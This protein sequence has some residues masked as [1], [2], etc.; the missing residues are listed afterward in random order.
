MK[1]IFLATALLS[2]A[3]AAF[4]NP[5]PVTNTT[6]A[7]FKAHKIYCND[8]FLRPS[9]GENIACYNHD[10]CYSDPQGR[11]R[12]ECD[13][14]YLSDMR[15]AGLE[16]SGWLKYQALRSWGKF[17]WDRCREHDKREASN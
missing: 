14:G 13:E 9:D 7:P 6:K 3:A 5:V 15:K 10:A 12:K 16:N 11:S 2:I 1:R 17:S 4:A 8:S